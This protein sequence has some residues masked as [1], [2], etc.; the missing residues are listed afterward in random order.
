[1]DRHHRQVRAQIEQI[2]RADYCRIEGVL[3][4]QG[5]GELHGHFLGEGLFFFFFRLWC[6]GVLR[7]YRSVRLDRSWSWE[8]SETFLIRDNMDYQQSRLTKREGASFVQ[9]VYG[10]AG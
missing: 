1:M 6:Y 2:D 7:E 8:R 9:G 3:G 4:N 10:L 5:Y